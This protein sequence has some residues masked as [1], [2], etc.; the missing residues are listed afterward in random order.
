MKVPGRIAKLISPVVGTLSV[1]G[2]YDAGWV[3]DT[4]N[5]IES[6]SRIQSLVDDGLFKTRLEDAGA[7]IR[8]DVK[9]PFWNFTWRFD[10]PYWVS[11]PEVN[12]ES[13]QSDWRYNFSIIAT[14]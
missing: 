1:Y 12:A 3:K 11:H 2:F 13:K 8:S 4:H 7:S 10:V 14:F 6:S 5:P 9:W